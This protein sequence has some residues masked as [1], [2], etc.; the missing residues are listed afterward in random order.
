MRNLICVFFLIFLATT[1]LQTPTANAQDSAKL[2]YRT[3]LLYRSRFLVNKRSILKLLN[4]GNSALLNW[5]S[6][7]VR[8]PNGYPGGKAVQEFNEK[9]LNMNGSWFIRKQNC[10]EW[11]SGFRKVMAMDYTEMRILAAWRYETYSNLV[12]RNPQHAI[13][14]TW[15]NPFK[16]LGYLAPLSQ[17]EFKI[18]RE[19]ENNFSINKCLEYFVEEEKPTTSQIETRRWVKNISTF[20]NPEKFCSDLIL[21]PTE[22]AVFLASIQMRPFVNWH[23]EQ[24][25]ILVAQKNARYLSLIQDNPL[26]AVISSPNPSPQEI[27]RGLNELKSNQLSRQEPLKLDPVKQRLLDR[28]L[29]N[30]SNGK[31]LVNAELFQLIEALSKVARIHMGTE[32]ALSFTTKNLPQKEA[33]AVTT[34]ITKMFADLEAEKSAEMWIETGVLLG[35]NVLCFLPWG[36]VFT[37][38]RSVVLRSACFMLMGVPVN[39][40]FLLSAMGEHEAVMKTI[41]STVSTNYQLAELA[42]LDESSQTAAW[43]LAF[44]PL[45]FGV[46]D[47]RTVLGAFLIK[48]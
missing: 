37:A 19:K 22:N 45:S 35:A 2:D 31:N 10:G 23:E 42:E 28:F 16:T 47:F 5:V 26:L 6:D 44:M 46:K 36:R 38:A 27:I 18:E 48:R 3:S 30:G 20:A 1:A 11:L 40:A 8:N 15:L 24:K 25:R 13:A 43:S 17:S 12:N 32:E 34:E 29:A 4:S 41:F 14:G 21:K 7:C 39:S 33:E 9:L